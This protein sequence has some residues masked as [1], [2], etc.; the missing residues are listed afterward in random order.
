MEI[1][2]HTVTLDAPISMA[3]GSQLGWWH[4]DALPLAGTHF[5]GGHREPTT[6][7]GLR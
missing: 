4:L 1:E 5:P 2:G 7:L 6:G 3:L